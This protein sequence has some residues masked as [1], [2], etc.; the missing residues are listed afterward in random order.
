MRPEAKTSLS[1][2]DVGATARL[3]CSISGR[4][5]PGLAGL[6]PHT[7]WVKGEREIEREGERESESDNRLRG[8]TSSTLSFSQPSDVVVGR[9]SWTTSAR[10]SSTSSKPQVVNPILHHCCKRL[11]NVRIL[12]NLVIYDS[13]LVSLEH[14]LLSRH[15]SQG[16]PASVWSR[17]LCTG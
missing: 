2:D 1:R 8:I 10:R 17:R 5:R 3:H 14:L 12:V 16:G 13:V 15:P 9:R 11:T 4:A 7:L 6:R